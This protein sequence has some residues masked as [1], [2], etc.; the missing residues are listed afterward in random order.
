MKVGQKWALVTAVVL[1]AF[2]IR[3][4]LLW[5]ARSAPGVE[6]QPAYVERALTAD[7]VVQ[8]RKLYIDSLKSARELNG[9]TVW[10]QAGYQLPYFVAAGK[11]ADLRRRAGLLPSVERLVIE[12]VVEQD[13]PASVNDRFPAGRQYFVLFTRT[14]DA[15]RYAAPVGAT[16]DGSPAF[17]CDQIFYYDDPHQLYKHWPAEVWAAVDKHEPRPGMSELQVAMALG[18]VQESGSSSVGNRTIHYTAGDQKWTVSFEKDKAVS[19]NR[20]N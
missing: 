20:E 18:Q 5:R 11:R 6:K 19:V 1:L 17:Q 9:K 13:V 3:L 10:M 12:D 15:K 14:G 4:F 7:D 2:G 16:E 8:P